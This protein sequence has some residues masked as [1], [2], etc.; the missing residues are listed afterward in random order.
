MTLEWKV[1]VLTPTEM[2]Y[3]DVF[4][5]EKEGIYLLVHGHMRN[6]GISD[7]S[8]LN[9]LPAQEAFIVTRRKVPR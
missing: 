9:I 8:I 5:Q 3:L 2:I 4:S 7:Y 1:T 6:E